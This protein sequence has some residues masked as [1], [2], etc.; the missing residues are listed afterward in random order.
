MISDIKHSAE[1]WN[2]GG[3][4]YSLTVNFIVHGSTKTVTGGVEFFF[5][6]PCFGKLATWWVS[7]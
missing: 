1:I 5:Y 3:T 7:G 6:A 2:G 4:F